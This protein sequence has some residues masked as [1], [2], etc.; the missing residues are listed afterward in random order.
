MK[1]P[2][3]FKFLKRKNQDD[4][5][6]ITSIKANSVYDHYRSTD[7]SDNN[8]DIDEFYKTV[9]LPKDIYYT[10]YVQKYER[11][12]I[13]SRIVKS[14]VYGAWRHNPTVY[15][16]K[17]KATAFNTDYDRIVKE[18]SLYTHLTQLDLLA[19]LG[20]YAVLF[21]GLAD[22]T[23]PSIPVARAP[24]ISYLSTIPEN[25]ADIQTSDEDAASPRFGLPTSYSIVV[26]VEATASITRTV[27]WTRVIHV[28][29]NTLDSEV[30]GIPYLKP[31]FNNLI[32][33][34]TLSCSS[35]V[36]YKF[37]GR[38]G[39]V[40]QPDQNS[41]MNDNSIQQDREAISDFLKYNRRWLYIEGKEITP[42]PVQVVSPEDHVNVQLK[43]ISAATK[44]P[45]RMLTGSERG[46]LASSQDERAW[47]AFLEERRINVVERLIL[48]PLIDRLVE[49][50]TIS[51]PLA[52]EYT[53]EWP[54][55]IVKSEKEQVEISLLKSQAIK[56]RGEAIGGEDVYTDEDLYK[57][58]GDTDEEIQAK[59]NKMEDNLEKESRMKDKEKEDDKTIQDR[60][61]KIDNA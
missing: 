28:A 5:K 12:D 14:P 51:A 11:Q 15:D 24:Q 9:G 25:R 6:Q 55:L 10:D 13:A 49:I 53:I 8:Y 4:Q 44:I 37:G 3:L 56:T 39:V 18:L 59:M 17:A 20:Q 40:I 58:W 36:M 30:Y 41:L 60:S 61:D 43:L 2:N 54:P 21:L 19:T 16:D 22:N 32:G 50:G 45:L 34:E 1:I 38:P 48:R 29:E 35:P 52:G 57:D 7:F 42:L 27:D 26:N 31:V 46:E 47:L 33:L 23:D